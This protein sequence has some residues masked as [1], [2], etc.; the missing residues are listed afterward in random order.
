M[1]Y[2]KIENLLNSLWLEIEAYSLRSMGELSPQEAQDL[3]SKTDETVAEAERQLSYIFIEFGHNHNGKGHQVDAVMEQAIALSIKAD[4]LQ[5]K[6]QPNHPH[7]TELLGYF[8]TALDNLMVN[9]RS[10]FSHL[11][12]VRYSSRSFNYV[13]CK[14]ISLVY[15]LCIIGMNRLFL[16][17]QRL[18]DR[19]G[20]AG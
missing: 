10:K 3:R 15:V 2:L 6:E 17:Q 14:C 18:L 4:T 9:I 20:F 11:Q 12:L 5:N 13:Y 1:K 19:S 8:M 16:T 7:R